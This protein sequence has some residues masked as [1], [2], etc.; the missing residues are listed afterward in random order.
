MA[1]ETLFHYTDIGAV[2]SIV[3]L[4]KLW[5]TH[6]EFLNDSMELLEGTERIKQALKLMRAVDS[7]RGEVE[8]RALKIVEELLVDGLALGYSNNPL[9]VCLFV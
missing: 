4:K 6:M 8:L 3:R 5:L 9:F 2:E 7:T 1:Q